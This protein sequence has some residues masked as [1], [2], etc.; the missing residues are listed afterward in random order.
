M[1]SNFTLWVDIGF[2]I[3]YPHDN[4][5]DECEN[6]ETRPKMNV[7]ERGTVPNIHH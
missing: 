2:S 7:W 4:S 6:G 5:A 1:S 3:I